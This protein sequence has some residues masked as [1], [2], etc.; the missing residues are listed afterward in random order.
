[1]MC[2]LLHVSRSGYYDW[3]QRA[4]SARRGRDRQLTLMI[5]RIHLESNGVYGARKV[6]RELQAVGERCLRTEALP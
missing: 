3:T 1:M 6:H 5:R 4:E 2:R